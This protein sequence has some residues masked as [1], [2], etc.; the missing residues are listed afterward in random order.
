MIKNS[1][2]LVRIPIFRKSQPL[3]VVVFR[4]WTVIGAMRMLKI[5]LPELWRH[6]VVSGIGSV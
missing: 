5:I 6:Q 4:P 3:T 1:F 2:F